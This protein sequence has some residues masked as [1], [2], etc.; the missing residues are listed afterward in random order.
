MMTTEAH[1]LEK[2]DFKQCA[3]R[4]YHQ[5]FGAEICVGSIGFPL[6]DF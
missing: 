4:Q 3:E 2:I 1:F 5:I 6:V